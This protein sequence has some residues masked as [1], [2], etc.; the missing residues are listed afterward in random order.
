M[1]GLPAQILETYLGPPYFSVLPT[2]GPQVSFPE[3][4]PSHLMLKWVHEHTEYMST[5]QGI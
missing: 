3:E 1:A 5:S 2:A 4:S